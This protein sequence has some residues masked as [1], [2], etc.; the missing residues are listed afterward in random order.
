MKRAYGSV[1]LLVTAALIAVGCSSSSKSASTSAASTARGV[2]SK[3]V[4]VGGVASITSPTGEAFP[5]L[6]AGAKARFDRANREGGVDGRMINYLGVKD[7]G[8][9]PTRTLDVA[10]SLVQQSHVFAIVPM[11]SPSFLAP[12]GDFLNQQQVPYV[13]W[14]F[15]PP[16]C[17]TT[18]GFGFTGC[19]IG[20]TSAIS[21]GVCGALLKGIGAK[22]G[23]TV[24][25]AGGDSAGSK[26]GN[27]LF[28]KCY[29]SYGMK[30]V[31]NTSAIPESHTVD[32]TP[33]IDQVMHSNNGGPPDIVL[34]NAIFGVVVGMSGGL[35]AAGFKGVVTDNISYVP[36]LL[37]SQPDLAKSLDGNY[38]SVQ[39]QPQEAGGDAIKQ[40]EADLTASGS[41]ATITLGVSVGYWSAD[42]FIRQLEAVGKDLTPARFAA[43]MNK[44][45]TYKSGFKQPG[46]GDVSFPDGHTNPGGGCEAL[47]HIVGTSY[48]ATEPLACYGS[49]PST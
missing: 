35:K 46:I 16:F 21:K 1:G 44:G 48:Q 28:A 18:F 38:V 30:I 4:T 7:D 47:V 5:G 9:D 2:T 32:Y 15:S 49:L 23:M 42:F 39:F 13:G 6:N 29:P 11:T 41:P 31:L 25:I 19:A 20:K 40:M 10:T 24:A 34:V 43:V 37:S 3:S 27:A 14:G 36:G 45:F 12:T 17:D 22:P 8:E 26:S 33:F